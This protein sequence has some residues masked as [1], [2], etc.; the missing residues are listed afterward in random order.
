[1]MSRGTFEWG[2]AFTTTYWADPKERLVALI[3][4][5]ILGRTTGL[6]DAFKRGRLLGAPIVILAAAN[7]AFEG[8]DADY[9]VTGTVPTRPGSVAR[10]H[11]N[12]LREVS[13]P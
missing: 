7:P 12:H 5:N 2:G 11:S 4:T 6:G 1:V 13:A 10:S 8:F 9:I 3:Y